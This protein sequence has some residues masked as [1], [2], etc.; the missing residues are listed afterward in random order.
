V[1]ISN[2]DTARVAHTLNRKPGADGTLHRLFCR[3]WPKCFGRGGQERILLPLRR[4]AARSFFRPLADAVGWRPLVRPQAIRRGI[5]WALATQKGSTQKRC[6]VPFSFPIGKAGCATCPPVDADLE[7]AVV[8]HSTLF[9]SSAL[10]PHAGCR[11]LSELLS[12]QKRLPLARVA[13]YAE[14]S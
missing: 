1:P 13:G 3:R 5:R 9:P 10:S 11:H 12:N 4:A 6:Q 8:M 2:E 7:F 14:R